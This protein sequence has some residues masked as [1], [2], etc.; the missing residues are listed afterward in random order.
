MFFPFA[1]VLN[2]FDLTRLSESLSLVLT[3]ISVGLTWGVTA[4]LIIRR[5]SQFITVLLWGMYVS[6]LLVIG[7]PYWMGNNVYF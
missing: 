6:L 4:T 7:S 3:L 1:L 2:E 5:N